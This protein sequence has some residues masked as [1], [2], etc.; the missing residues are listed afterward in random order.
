[1]PERRSCLAG[2]K[3]GKLGDEP[4]RQFG[5]H[6]WLEGPG[7]RGR[8]HRD[9]GTS[10]AAKLRSQ[11]VETDPGGLANLPIIEAPTESRRHPLG[12]PGEDDPQNI[13]SVLVGEPVST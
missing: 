12:P 4:G 8:C 13:A 6:L 2:G 1:T 3:S 11:P 7:Q 10:A 9:A 5:D